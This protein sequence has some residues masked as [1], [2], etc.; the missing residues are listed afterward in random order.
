MAEVVFSPEAAEDLLSLYDYIANSAGEARALAFVQTIR[1]YCME[2][3]MFPQRGTQRDDLRPGLRI[4][5][6]R[7]RI[8]IA[9]HIAPAR[10]VIDRVLYAGR[11]LERLFDPEGD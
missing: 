6:F 4:T 7:R 8:T 5:G 3:A 9:F 1:V 2:F 11:D 10:I